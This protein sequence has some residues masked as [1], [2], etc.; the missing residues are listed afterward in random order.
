MDKTLQPLVKALQA[1]KKV[2][3]FLGAGISTSAGIPDFRSP[4]TGLYSNL[5]KFDLPFPEAVFD[6]DYFREHP[7]AFYTLAEELY[8]GQFEPTAFHYL[9]RLLQD[10][11]L[12]HRVYTQNIDTLERIAGVE[13]KYLVE[14]HG[15]F[16]NNH[17]IDCHEEMSTEDLKSHM[18]EKRIPK[19]TECEGYVKPDIVF[20]GEGL[21]SKFFETWEE[22][23]EKVEIAIVAGTSLS[24]YPFASLP[25]EVGDDALRVLVNSEAVGDFTAGK[26][27]SDILALEDC[28]VVAKKLIEI[29]SWEEEFE[30][31]TNVKKTKVETKKD[32]KEVS[33]DIS[34]DISEASVKEDKSGKEETKD[35]TKENDV[36]DTAESSLEEAVKKLHI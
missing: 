29:L 3:F 32:L 19:C 1:G 17:C 33:E 36:N 8:P 20:F 27:K 16:V 26:R 10:K 5:A 7:R 12:L 21:P 4:G 22:D 15:S 11:D 28:D 18:N 24:V 9:V 2:T 23:E 14:A 30:K 34:R 35:A 31:L 6:I 25:A 13:D